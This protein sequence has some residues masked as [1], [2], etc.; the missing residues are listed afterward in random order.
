MNLRIDKSSAKQAAERNGK[1]AHRTIQEKA[2]LCDQQNV[3]FAIPFELSQSLHN[4]P[5]LNLDLRCSVQWR[6]AF[7]RIAGIEGKSV[8]A[9]RQESQRS[10]VARPREAAS[11]RE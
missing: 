4:C 5:M 8:V 1:S 7:S 6:H 10:I 2:Q 11:T 3:Q 9:E